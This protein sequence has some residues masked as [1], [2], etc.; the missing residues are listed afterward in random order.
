MTKRLTP[1]D[2]TEYDPNMFLIVEDAKMYYEAYT[3]V[4]DVRSAK[5]ELAVGT[6]DGRVTALEQSTPV[7]PGGKGA[8]LNLGGT[9]ERYPTSEE[10]V[11]GDTPEETSFLVVA[12]NDGIY[13]Y[14]PKSK[15]L[16][17]PKKGG[18]TVAIHAS[19]PDIFDAGHTIKHDTRI[20][21]SGVYTAKC[22]DVGLD[23]NFLSYD[24]A[25]I[26]VVTTA[27]ME[28]QTALH[29]D[30]TA[31][32][33]FTPGNNVTPWSFHTGTGGGGGGSIDPVVIQEINRRL[34]LLEA[35]PDPVGTFEDLSDVSVDVVTDVNGLLYLGEDGKVRG[36][37]VN[38]ML[39][40]GYT[41]VQAA[42]VGFNSI[43]VTGNVGA[44]V[45][46]ASSVITMKGTAAQEV[47][48]PNIVPFDT[49][50]PST[51]QIRAG[52]ITY[53]VN[54][55]TTDNKTLVVTSGQRFYKDGNMD[56]SAVVVPP[57]TTL[58]YNPAIIDNGSG[59]M[60]ECY[61][62]LGMAQH[63]GGAGGASH[64]TDLIDT[65]DTLEAKKYLVVN[66]AGDAIQMSNLS[67]DDVELLAGFAAGVA[68]GKAL[69]SGNS[70]GAEVVQDGRNNLPS[71]LIVDGPVLIASVWNSSNTLNL[72]NIAKFDTEPLTPNCVREGR[73]TTIYNNTS[74]NRSITI[75][76][77]PAVAGVV[78]KNQAATTVDTYT[79]GPAKSIKLMPVFDHLA[80]ADNQ[81][82]WSIL[83]CNDRIGERVFDQAAHFG[84]TNVQ[85]ATVA[86]SRLVSMIGSN[87]RDVMFP[88][89][90]PFSHTAA[91][92]A[93]QVRQGKIFTVWGSA[94]AN[95]N[96]KLAA[97][98][99]FIIN[100][101]ESD[102]DRV[103]PPGIMETYFPIVISGIQKWIQIARHKADGSSVGFEEV[104]ARLDAIEA[105][106]NIDLG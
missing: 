9:P 69:V 52:R 15:L 35:K 74:N 81:R 27:D 53:F 24:T 60:M 44:V 70:L 2:W 75:K 68:D 65:T 28:Y 22:S 5:N 20:G 8:Y 21:K 45:V 38:P 10:M 14:N 88:E 36:G 77:D 90:V 46:A 32:R 101:V 91:L 39:A 30:G 34:A 29:P 104:L 82:F 3:D 57:K 50:K 102:A 84:S 93:H 17:P 72:P 40:M 94:S 85:Q 83:E 80:S 78:L 58:I 51:T 19:F 33:T 100:N 6:L 12:R 23:G 1:P 63:Q 18:G 92:E 96:L 25:K 67:T 105:N 48:L 87:Q 61:V 98:Q 64:F 95:M 71:S 41:P 54:T 86:N 55:S 66:D 11:A 37:A 97:G 31:S 73:T 89:V 42:S 26:L 106:P 62:F 47:T 103:V 16:I 99:K 43:P 59:A 7:G 76:V 79:L 13:F 4:L 56:S 49:Y